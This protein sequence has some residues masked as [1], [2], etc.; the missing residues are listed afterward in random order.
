MSSLF[1]LPLSLQHIK[2]WISQHIFVHKNLI[3]GGIVV[4]L[5]ALWFCSFWTSMVKV[6][7]KLV[8]TSANFANRIEAIFINGFGKL[9]TNIHFNNETAYTNWKWWWNNIGWTTLIQLRSL[10]DFLIILSL[11]CFFQSKV[12]MSHICSGETMTCQK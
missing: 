7:S 10:Y 1:Q 9:S 8:H 6:R 5:L 4:F 11:W 2:A 3:N 12:W